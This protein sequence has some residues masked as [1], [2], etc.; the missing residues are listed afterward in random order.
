MKTL[1]LFFILA[2][3]S[4]TASSQNEKCLAFS[5]KIVE[6]TSGKILCNSTNEDIYCMKASF[7]EKFDLETIK[8]ICDTTAKTTKVSFN[9]RLN[10][11]KNY[12]KELIVSNKKL[13]VTIYFNDK[14]LYFE[15]PK[16]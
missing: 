11:D 16:E 6:N 5:N 10:A 4:V 1:T 9:W 15:F 12:E 8:T 3:M 7:S 14:F 13:L 2:L